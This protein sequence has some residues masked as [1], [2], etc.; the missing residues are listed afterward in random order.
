VTSTAPQLLALHG[1]L[2]SQHDQLLDMEKQQMDMLKSLNV[3]Q[4]AID[5]IQA[6]LT[7]GPNG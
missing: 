6:R 5:D 1:V 3:I 7:S 4:V 2:A